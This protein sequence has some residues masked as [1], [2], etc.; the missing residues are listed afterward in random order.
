M[1]S[2]STHDP[3]TPG[4]RC[5]TCGTPL[6]GR[7]CHEC[8]EK[9]REPADLTLRAFA[10]YA[11]EAVTNADSKLYRT[12]RLLASRPGLLTREFIT[13]RRTRYV[14]PLQLFLLINVVYFLS[15][16][17]PIR[18]NAFTTDLGFHNTQ[19]IY[20]STARSLL[21]N[22]VGELPVRGPGEPVEYW[23]GRWNEDQLAYR[24]QFNQ[25]S[26][27]YAN[28]LVIVMVP[29]F[30][31]CLRLLRR[32]TTI[33]R[34]LIFSLHFFVILLLLTMLLP[35]ALFVV[36]RL[37]VPLAGTIATDA[38]FS[39]LISAALLTW[40][41]LAFRR[42]HGD[43]RVAAAARG[44]AALLLLFTVITLYR[45]LLFFVVFAFV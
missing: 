15:L 10:H 42:V 31:V 28:S 19:P 7:Y 6:A 33:V 24:Q 32:S 18:T 17:T 3:V 25:A 43:S 2:P 29:L 38:G 22:R 35:A 5:V 1:P 44:V 21:E 39:L 9:R 20:G 30:A 12:L 34:E 45:G 11:V 27:R 41:V 13:G 23:I 40:L 36:Y 37:G 8:G 16:Q 26:P 4:D 14:A